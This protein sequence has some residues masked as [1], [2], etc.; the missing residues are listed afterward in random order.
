MFI[1]SLDSEIKGTS[2]N[3]IDPQERMNMDGSLTYGKDLSFPKFMNISSLNEKAINTDKESEHQDTMRLSNL[4]AKLQS[5]T[6]T[7]KKDN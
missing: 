6:E 2:S 7:N 5:S 3:S 4:E 1:D